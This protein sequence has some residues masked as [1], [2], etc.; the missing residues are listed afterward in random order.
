MK[1]DNPHTT[2]GARKKRKILAAWQN[3]MRKKQK[4]RLQPG[5]FGRNGEADRHY[6]A[7]FP[8]LADL[9][10]LAAAGATPFDE[11]S[12]CPDV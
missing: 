3:K 10:L 7:F 2:T 11:P 1:K 9:D 4:A 8:F 5:F 6:D 12:S